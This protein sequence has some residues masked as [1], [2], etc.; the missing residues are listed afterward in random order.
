MI[1]NE[2]YYFAVVYD[3]DSNMLIPPIVQNNAIDN[4]FVPTTDLC[5]SLSTEHSDRS[6]DDNYN[7]T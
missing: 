7:W 4:R 5:H 3:V 2:L 6:I 1:I